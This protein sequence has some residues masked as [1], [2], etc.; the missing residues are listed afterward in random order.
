MAESLATEQTKPNQSFLSSFS[1]GDDTL[2]T[3]IEVDQVSM[4]FNM[5]AEQLNSLKEYA[6]SLARHELKFKEFRALDNISLTVKR[7]D[8]FG[9]MGTNGSGKSTLLKIIAGVLDP[10]EGTCTINGSIAPLI[11]LG[12]GFD[13]ELTARENIYL[14]GALLGYPK[15]FIDQHFEEIVNFAEIRAF[16][17]MPMKNYSSGMVARVAFAIATVIVPDILIVDEVLSVGDFMFQQKCERR[18]QSLIRDYGVT[19]LIVSHNSD[20]IER[21]CNKAIWIE[22]GHTRMIGP[23]D[24]VCSIYRSI[25]GRIGS[26]QAETYAFDMM[27]SPLEPRKDLL[28]A[29]SGKDRYHIAAQLFERSYRYASNPFVVIA[30]GEDASSCL[31][32]NTLAATLEAGLLLVKHGNVPDDVADILHEHSPS[33]LFI[34]GSDSFI[35]E[36]TVEQL[37]D[38]TNAEI[39]IIDGNTLQDLTL[40]VYRA[41][42][43]YGNGW[44][45]TALVTYDGCIGDVVSFVPYIYQHN[46]PL[47]FSIGNNQLT[48]EINELIETKQFTRLVSLGGLNFDLIDEYRAQ[49]IEVVRIVGEDLFDANCRI[50][51]WQIEQ[52]LVPEDELVFSSVWNVYDILALGAYAGIHH[53]FVLLEDAQSLDSIAYIMNFV[54][55]HSANIDTLT[56]VGEDVCSNK[57][58]QKL[59]GKAFETSR[60]IQTCDQEGH[61]VGA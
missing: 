25:G 30:S 49:G 5:A 11:E 40:A 58:D 61:A 55:N 26:K 53:A 8:V 2:E 39:K 12:A 45:N 13:L 52:G 22:K 34:V 41:G 9:I 28:Q 20:Q 18:I 19:V 14:N 35:A 3:M 4:I 50:N 10:S 42:I 59:I 32:A 21:L 31:L 44:G 46:C 56:F 7:G 23:A 57:N 15:E 6:I 17:D 51:E 37:Y 43:D 29:V 1:F 47:F 27:M 48:K 36:K 54:A 16:L 24:E 38:L 33:K 60:T